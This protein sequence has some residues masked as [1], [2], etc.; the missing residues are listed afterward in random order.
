MWIVSV[1]VPYCAGCERRER[2]NDVYFKG[3]CI[4]SI[5]YL[6]EFVKKGPVTIRFY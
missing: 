2:N 1:A 5:E 6:T 3:L 4:S